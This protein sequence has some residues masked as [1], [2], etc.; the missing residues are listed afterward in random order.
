MLRLKALFRVAAKKPPPPPPEKPLFTFGNEPPPAGI[1]KFTGRVM[2]AVAGGGAY[3]QGDLICFHARHIWQVW[4]EPEV[5]P[6]P[7][8]DLHVVNV[9]IA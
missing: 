7:S 2:N 1:F 8:N 5:I 6:L 3:A 4:R 9:C